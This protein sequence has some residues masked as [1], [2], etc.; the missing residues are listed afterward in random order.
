VHYIA[1][2]LR[3][4]GEADAEVLEKRLL[5]GSGFADATEANLA[6]AGGGPDNIGAVQG[7]EQS[8]RLHRR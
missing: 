3:P 1:I 6:A 2:E 8:E 7:G 4:F 5:L